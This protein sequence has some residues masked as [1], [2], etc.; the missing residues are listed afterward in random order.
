MNIKHL[1]T[2]LLLSMTLLLGACVDKVSSDE[3]TIYGTFTADSEDL[4][5]MGVDSMLRKIVDFDETTMGKA[6]FKDGYSILNKSN[7]YFLYM[8]RYIQPSVQGYS[9]DSWAIAL[10]RS[11]PERWVIENLEGSEE[12][13]ETVYETETTIDNKRTSVAVKVDYKDGMYLVYYAVPASMIKASNDEEV[14]ELFNKHR[15]SK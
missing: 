2:L 1:S 9:R 15:Y 6:A 13:K 5:R 7:N 4:E 10:Q 3:E 11:N 8:G 12:Y 14:V